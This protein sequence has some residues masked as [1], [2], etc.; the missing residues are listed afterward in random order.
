MNGDR[1]AIR[2]LFSLTTALSTIPTVTAIIII[3]FTAFPA[4][5]KDNLHAKANASIHRKTVISVAPKKV[6]QI[7]NTVAAQDGPNVTTGRTAKKANVSINLRKKENCGAKTAPW[8]YIP[9]VNG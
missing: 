6:A 9:T 7:K 5:H 3:N 2:T 8:N 1:T 4:V